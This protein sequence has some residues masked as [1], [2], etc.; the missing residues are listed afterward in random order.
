MN[1]FQYFFCFFF[2]FFL[3]Q[4]GHALGLD[5][6]YDENAIMYPIY[7]NEFKGLHEDDRKGIQSLYG[8]RGKDPSKKSRIQ[9][10]LKS[11]RSYVRWKAL[12]ISEPIKKGF[13]YVAR[14]N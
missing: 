1:I 14:R 13:R 3:F 12:A 2:I 7:R 6:S 5:H 10:M 8:P 11:A 9:R 4:L